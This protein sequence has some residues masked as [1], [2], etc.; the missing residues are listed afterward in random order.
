MALD[1]KRE[2]T[3]AAVYLLLFSVVTGVHAVSF[4]SGSSSS[5]QH[6]SSIFIYDNG[7]I[8]PA[9]API[10]KVG[11]VYSLTNDVY[12][13]I[14]VQKSNIVFDGNGQK[15]YGYRGTGVLLQNVTNV[16][17]QN[18]NLMYFDYG[19]YLD[20]SNQ[21][22]LKVNTLTNC[23]IKLA[24]NSSNNYITANNVGKVVTVESSNDNTIIGNAASGISVTWSTNVTIRNNVL[25]DPKRANA[26]LTSG[27]YTEGISIDNSA[28]CN[29]AGNTIERKGLGVNI[30]YSTNLTFTGN[31]LRDNQFGFKLLGNNLQSYL[32]NIDNTNTV[33]GKTV[34]F[35][36]NKTNYQVPNSAG[37]IAAINCN[38]ITVQGWTSTSNWDGVLFVYTSNSKIA[39]SN[40]KDNF[41]ALRF[42]NVSGCTVTQN[43][44][45]N[46]QYAAFYFEDTTNFT[47]TRNNVLN[48]GCFFDIWHN[49]ANNTI[50]HN[51]FVGNWTG[52]LDKNLNSQWN[53]GN[54]GNYWSCY[55]GVDRDHNGIS[56]TPFLIDTYSGEKD[57]YP[58]M[59]PYNDM[60][61]PNQTPATVDLLLAMP[62]EYI[63]Y[64]ITNINGT[65]WA[66]IDGIYP[67][68]LIS[69][70]NQP[71]SLVYPT[72]PNT[73]NIHVI[74][75]GR[76]LSFG[77]YSEIDPT[78]IHYTDIGSWSLIYCAATPMTQDFLLEIHYE[79]P[80]EII[81]GSYT[82]LYD[83]NISPYLSPSSVNSIAHF[84]VH[85]EEDLPNLN[86]YTT[87]FN[88]K[89]TTLRYGSITNATTKTATFDIISEY[90]KPHS[91]DIAFVLGDATVPEAPAWTI[92]LVLAATTTTALIYRQKNKRKNGH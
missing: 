83:L 22:T 64:T 28:N 30:W 6:Y 47:I 15:I 42:S 31:T 40:L 29:I 13:G 41:N 27:V 17:V 78:T 63:N 39:N 38:S 72:P 67:M 1:K 5:V 12:V 61:M 9:T 60:D 20:N 54:E 89:W 10:L 50:Y 11:N 91:G 59:T 3:L 84:T 57:L 32:Q 86:V 52:A 92:V 79:H 21:T 35:L 87:G 19:I 55:T 62:E 2:L 34:Y 74:L 68:H 77:N 18:L 80:L 8:E 4:A 16:T 51:N 56:D 7:T 65:L 24:Q 82:F 73:T 53:N 75:D 36:V 76:E 90:D 81:N 25:S 23:G 33:N 58:R 70:Y 44:M 45:S 88:G 66:K 49:S 46:N 48:N 71:L 85:L 37:W 69:G 43:T 26:T 14:A